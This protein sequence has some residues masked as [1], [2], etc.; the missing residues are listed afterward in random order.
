MAKHS[1]LANWL[2]AIFCF[3]FCPDFVCVQSQGWPSKLTHGQFL[4]YC[5]LYFFFPYFFFSLTSIDIASLAPLLIK[6][7]A[8][9]TE[10]PQTSLSSPSSSLAD[11]AQTMSESS[12]SRCSA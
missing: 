9:E 3:V 11:K 7:Y 8:Q 12:C 5:Y 10:A 1:K 6:I 2:W 4:L